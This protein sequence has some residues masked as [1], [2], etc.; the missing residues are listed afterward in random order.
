MNLRLM[1]Q[2]R[3]VLLFFL[4]IHLSAQ[5]PLDWPRFR[6]QI[7][8]NHPL[9]LQADLYRDQA[10]AAFLRAQGGFDPKAVLDLSNKNFKGQNYFQ[11]SEAGLKWPVGLGLEWTA[12]YNWAYGNFLNPESKLPTQGQAALGLTWTLGQGLLIDERR[13]NLRQSRIG[14][15]LS[16][17][18]RADALNDL[19]LEA[20]KA[21]WTWVLAD[22]QL[23]IYEQSLQ[24][25]QI[26]HQ[27]LLESFRQ[28]DKPAIDTLES[29]IQVQNRQLDLNFARLDLQNAGLTL[30]RF[31]W[32]SAQTPVS[33][34]EIPRPVS[35]LD[36]TAPVS[37]AVPPVENPS[38]VLS[39]H[40]Q[41]RMYAAKLNMLDIE[42]RW[43]QEKRKPVLDLSYYL[44]GNGWQFS[45]TPGT[46]GLGVLANDYKWG[47][48]FSFP[49]LNRKARGDW[50][51]TQIKIAQTDLALEQKKL[52]L[53]T[54]I[55]QY[56]NELQQLAAQITLYRDL[57]TN[58]RL[59]L[60]A[61]TEKF[62]Y[63]ESS[64]FLINT[65]EQRY[66]EAQNK[67]LKL[68]SEYQKSNAGLLW[69]SGAL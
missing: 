53:A 60:E 64:I 2:I 58:Y 23:Q 40:P 8:S 22:N 69:A 65:R 48:H 30:S 16:E 21:Y 27:G 44:L 42:R 14:L 59:L 62:K 41:I 61:E 10:R 55:R 68:L 1:Q 67:Y 3:F 36:N 52:D 50:Q 35:L 13:A 7:L 25:A 33:P 19:L 32:T 37:S 18:E 46:E 6:Q 51:V 45:P 38:A 63:G 24:Q 20:A 47:L 43:K 28:G 54:K 31:Y 17:A 57:S 5:A 9:A 12:N 11:Y 56:Q 34:G 39:S 66:L 29:F 4:P 49:I 26:R 15:D